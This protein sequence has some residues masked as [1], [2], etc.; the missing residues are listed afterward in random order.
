MHSES[1]AQSEQIIGDIIFSS[2]TSTSSSII[3]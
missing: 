1:A 2:S 3:I